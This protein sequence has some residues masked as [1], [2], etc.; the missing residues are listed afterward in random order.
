MVIITD[1]REQE[2][3]IFPKVEGVS[4]EIRGLEV[5]DYACQVG[6]RLLPIRIERKSIADLFSS[7]SSGY[8]NEKAKIV[9]ARDLGLKYILAIEGTLFDI[10]EGHSYMKDGELHY[11]K[12][13]GLSQ[14]KQLYTMLAKGYFDQLWFFKSRAE[15]AFGILQ[16]FLSLE[17]LYGND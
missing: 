6:E 11:S 2:E 8:E 1:S 5:G 16:Y 7:F 17:R 4:W 12:K 14:V 15:M 10:R 13:D 9:K 3:L